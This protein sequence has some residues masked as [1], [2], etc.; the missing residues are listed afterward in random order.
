MI[1]DSL[2]SEHSLLFG[3]HSPPS[4]MCIFHFEDKKGLHDGYRNDGGL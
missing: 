2:A 1:R 4:I 3:L